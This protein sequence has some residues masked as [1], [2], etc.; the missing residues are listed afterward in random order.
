MQLIHS[1]RTFSILV[2][3]LIGISS[4][5]QD[6]GIGTA[7]PRSHL[8]IKGNLTVGSSYSGVNAAPANGAIIN[9]QVGIGNNSPSS[10]AILDL[11][12]TGT[13]L[14]IVIPSMNTTAMNAI[15]APALGLTIF[16]TDINCLEV[17]LSAGVKNWKTACE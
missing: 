2:G 12:N 10:S 6:I 3:V 17:N 5:A 11:T 8:D 14:G 4:Q 9:G 13:N 7:S 15:A 1:L 16:N